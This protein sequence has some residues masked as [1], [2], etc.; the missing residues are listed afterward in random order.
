MRP[1]AD[2]F[3]AA[4]HGPV[5]LRGHLDHGD[6]ELKTIAQMPRSTAT[7]DSPE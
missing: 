2:P 3:R 1:A 5:T 6:R 7:G 4:G